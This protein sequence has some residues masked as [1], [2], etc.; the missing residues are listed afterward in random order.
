MATTDIQRNKIK[1]IISAIKAIDQN[2]KATI[3]DISDVYNDKLESTN[4]I[5]KK[6][7]TDFTSKVKGKTQN[8]KNIYE[9]I[10]DLAVTFLNDETTIKRNPKVKISE[11]TKLFR[12]SKQAAKITLQA[13]AQDIN[14]ETKR[15]LF[16][17]VCDPPINL[18]ATSLTISPKEFDF[19]G[20]LKVNPNSITGKLMYESPESTINGGIK[21]NR[22]LYNTFDT[23]PNPYNFKNQFFIS[24]DSGQQKFLVEGLN[25]ETRLGIFL[26]DYYSSIEYPD[27]D[28]IL[29]TAIQMVLG[30]D[31]VEPKTFKI[32]MKNLNRLLT[33]L[34][35]I[36]G[37][38]S[39]SKSPLLNTTDTELN[40]DETD[41]QNY[42]D[43]NDTEGIDLDDEDAWDR[44][45]LRFKDCENF[46]IP[47]NP[48]YSED[49]TYF[50]DKKPIDENIG[51]TLDKAA[52]EAYESSGNADNGGIAFEG[53]Q[54]SLITNY[55]LKI[56]RAII[57]SLL[58]PKIF[59]P[60]VVIYKI[61]KGGAL[62]VTDL[63]KILYNLFNNFIRKIFWRFIKEFW[64]LVKG[65]L[66]HFIQRIA[67][68]IFINKLKK[69]K[70]IIQILIN[71]IRKVLELKI[72]SCSDIFGAILQTI[73]TALNRPINIKIPSLLL[74]MA[75][76]LPGFSA[77]RAH[78]DAV[79][80]AQAYGVDMGPINGEDNKLVLAMKAIIDAISTEEDNNSYVIG[81]IKPSM[82][83]VAPGGGTALLTGSIV[84]KKF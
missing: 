13:T 24:W 64:K 83:P 44:R 8:R 16:G 48:N 28:H 78:I 81:T 80:R 60:I 38:P 21:F 17:S 63:I 23:T 31:G 25:N 10:V 30:G 69:L 15:T 75:D 6:S 5:I 68:R 34:F 45:V 61:L 27:I 42:F 73:T 4:G 2:P 57:A 54:L 67:F 40:E 71:L 22:E 49:F 50:L 65:D 33:K 59:F 18:N 29:K 26:N 77:D 41:L 32:G 55:I 72:T 79:S 84:G 82:I 51:N 1:S 47:I 35:S 46:E 39:T 70:V 14:N 74:L 66:L 37:K 58:S 12:Y 36:C 76:K 7:I 11:N 19:M 9:E 56:P 53:F 62:L 20:L 43:F 52:K 3:S